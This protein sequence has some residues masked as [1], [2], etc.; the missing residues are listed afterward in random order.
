VNQ[1]L[2]WW[3]GQLCCGLFVCAGGLFSGQN[4]YG[5]G[6]LLCNGGLFSGQSS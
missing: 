5:V 4:S 1:L 2:V 6:L 3:T